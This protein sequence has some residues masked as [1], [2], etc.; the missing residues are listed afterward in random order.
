MYVSL[1]KIALENMFFP[2]VFTCIQNKQT[3]G[4]FA[5]NKVATD[6]YS[7]SLFGWRAFEEKEWEGNIFVLIGY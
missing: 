3:N 2:F 5:C 6:M 4:G 7:S 1:G